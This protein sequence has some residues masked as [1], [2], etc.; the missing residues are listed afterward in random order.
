MLYFNLLLVSLSFF[1]LLI[2]SVP[3]L[4]LL[5]L[6]PHDE[7][8]RLTG[9]DPDAGKDRVQEEKGVKKDEMVR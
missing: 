6:W 4:L 5:S 2:L 8:S 7:K 1:P 9:K 3:K